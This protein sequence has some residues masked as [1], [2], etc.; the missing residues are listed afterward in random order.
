MAEFYLT[1][2]QVEEKSHLVHKD[3]C[4]VLPVMETLRYLGSFASG[5]AAY[6]KSR[7]I[8]N[9]IDFCPNCIP[10]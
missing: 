4:T 6:N 5:E 7:G 3:N 2:E 1:L 9:A 8:F 10:Q